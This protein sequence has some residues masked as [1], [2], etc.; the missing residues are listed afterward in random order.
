[1]KKTLTIFVL[2][3][4]CLGLGLILY[5][6]G[7]RMRMSRKIFGDGGGSNNDSPIVVGDTSTFF[8]YF[9]KGYNAIQLQRQNVNVWSDPYDDD[10]LGNFK[11]HGE[12]GFL[13]L[14]KPYKGTCV[15]AYDQTAGTS[16]PMPL[17]KNWY[18]NFNDSNGVTLF[19]IQDD[20]N[21]VET[22][23]PKGATLTP[24][25]DNTLV[26]TDVVKVYSSIVVGSKSGAGSPIPATSAIIHYCVGG[27]CNDGQHNDPCKK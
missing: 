2:L 5:R 13:G 10:G 19:A 6:N 9:Q 3:A 23:D 4:L 26:T 15:V 8:K 25:D 1:M 17:D 21:D 14:G 11:I 24:V 12:S 16:A 20:G 22:L 7:H 27:N 18:V